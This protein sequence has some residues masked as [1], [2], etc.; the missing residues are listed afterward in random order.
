MDRVENE[1]VHRRARIGRLLVSKADQRELRWFGSVER[2]DEFHF[3][4][5]C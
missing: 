4:E 5:G 2:M 3:P 1:E